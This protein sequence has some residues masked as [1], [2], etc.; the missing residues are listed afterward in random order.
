LKPIRA[1][2]ERDPGSG[3]IGSEYVLAVF[4]WYSGCIHRQKLKSEVFDTCSFGMWRF[5]NGLELVDID[6]SN[7]TASDMAIVNKYHIQGY[8]AVL[9]LNPDRTGPGCWIFNGNR[10]S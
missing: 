5:R 8:P 7:A 10:S 9:A 1:S 6:I 2:L 3:I 4:T